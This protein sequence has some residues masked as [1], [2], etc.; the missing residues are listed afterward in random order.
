MGSVILEDNNLNI[1][2]ID[3]PS[4]NDILKYEKAMRN[5]NLIKRKNILLHF[6]IRNLTIMPKMSLCLRYAKSMFNI[7]KF[8]D[9]HVDQSIIYVKDSK[10]E[11]WVKNRMFMI[12]KPVKRVT[13]LIQ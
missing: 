4:E 5:T 12:Y 6:D 13:I 9:N 11:K 3:N 7:K 2:L 10:W 8:I 1:T